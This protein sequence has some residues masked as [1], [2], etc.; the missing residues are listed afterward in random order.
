MDGLKTFKRVTLQFLALFILSEAWAQT[1]ES[2]HF[3]PLRFE[4]PEPRTVHLSNGIPVYLL[5]NHELPLITVDVL[6][7]RGTLYEPPELAGLFEIMADVMRTGGTATR[8]PWDV[9]E[10]LESMAASVELSLGREYGIA[11]L[12]LLAEDLP[13]GLDIFGDILRN[14]RF[15][16]DRVA[17]RKQQAIEGI[18]RRN[19]NP[20]NI[21][22]RLFPAYL[23]GKDHPLGAYETISGIESITVAD[24]KEAHKA[25]FHPEN[26]TIAASGDFDERRI[27]ALLER[28]F[29]TWKKAAAGAAASESLPEPGIYRGEPVVVYVEKDLNQ[30]TLLMGYTSLKRTP[31]NSDIFA[32]R[33]MNEIL[34]ES[35]FTSR[36]FREVRDKRGLAYSVGSY[37]DTSSYTFPGYWVA[38]AQT[39]AEKTVETASIM[40]EVI[41]S[42]KARPVGEEE[43]QVI[44]DSIVNSFVFSFES[45]SGVVRQRMIL[46]V[47]GYPEDYLEQYTGKIAQVTSADVLRVARRYLDLDHLII[48]VVGNDAYFETPLQTLGTVLRVDP[49]EL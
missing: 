22:F 49:S 29:G 43:L 18:R 48:L 6:V 33:V 38:F 5:E 34:G 11:T 47:R 20:S 36:L 40:I 9:D 35:S 24:L 8:S 42:M 23:Y 2:L 12:D 37:F 25:L 21:A 46:D 27:I 3:E 15:R 28:H 1:P 14:P 39:R 16:E 41:E 10:E 32:L 4:P 45:S 7:T 31:E 26:L 17:L 13:R 44:K 19:D 30:S